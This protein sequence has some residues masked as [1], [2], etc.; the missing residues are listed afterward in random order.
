V[1]NGSPP[2]ACLADFDFISTVS[3]PVQKLS[4]SAQTEGGTP[5]FKSPERLIPEEFG[6][7]DALPTQQADIY[8]FGLVIFQVR[9]QGHRYQP[10]LCIS[11]LGPHGRNSIPLS[12]Y[13]PVGRRKSREKVG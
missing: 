3:D 8:A 2:R 4:T 7:K 12:G 13:Q 1:S 10:F 9:K 11:S 5:W 6:K